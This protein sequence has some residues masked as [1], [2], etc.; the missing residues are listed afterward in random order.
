MKKWILASLAFIF[1]GFY[2]SAWAKNAD[3]TAAQD[4]IENWFAAMK[5]NQVDK[6]GNFLAPQFTSI[7]TDG[8]VRNK[9]QELILI[10]NLHMTQFKL[11]DFKFVQS[12]DTMVVTYKDEGSEMIDNKPVM[13][14]P[15]GRMAVMQKQND[16]W[17]ILA[18]ANLDVIG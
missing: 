17:L 4:I 12:G 5:N 7:H 18:Y 8:L 13:T 3:F 1:L 15:A 11:S 10:K 14:K 9:E 16:K 6:A 2:S